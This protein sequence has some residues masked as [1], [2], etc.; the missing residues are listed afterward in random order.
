MKD[1]TNGCSACVPDKEKFEV[2]HSRSRFG[3]AR[4]SWVQYDYRT[5]DG[6]LFSTIAPTV[7]IARTRR[8]VWL[9]VMLSERDQ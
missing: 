2:F 6:A 8:D 5:E 1:D 3:R 7:E 4:R 9:Q